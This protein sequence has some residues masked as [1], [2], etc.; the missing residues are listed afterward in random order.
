MGSG[1]PFP[2]DP[3]GHRDELE[4]DVGHAL[5]FDLPA[6]RFDLF[7]ASALT[8]KALEIS[9]HGAISC[10]TVRK[11]GSLVVNNAGVS[12]A[13]HRSV[14]RVNG[15]PRP[16]WISKCPLLEAG[17]STGAGKEHRAGG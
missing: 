10:S 12:T 2:H 8:D 1:N 13:C 6:H 17:W 7:V 4:V 11:P 9:G 16:G 15:G 3:S 5:R 14:D